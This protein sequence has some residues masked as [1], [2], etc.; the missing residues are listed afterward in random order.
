MSDRHVR[1]RRWLTAVAAAAVCTGMTVLAAAPLAQAASP[2]PAAVTAAAPRVGHTEVR[3]AITPVVADHLSDAVRRANDEGMAALV[4]ELDTPGGLITAMRQIVQT[5]LSAD[6]P[7][8]VYVSP[9]GADAG[10]AGTFVTLAAHVAAMAPATTIGAATPVDVQGGEVGDKIVN[11]AAA[12]A[13]AIATERGRN[14]DFAVA[15]VR[16]GRSI[17]ADEAVKIG[18]VDLIAPNL[19][20]LLADLD[21]RTVTLADGTRTLQTADAQVVEIDW[22]W[23]R[24]LLQWL[25]DPEVA[26]LLISIGTLGLIYELAQPGLGAGAV[27][28]GV[29][30]VL[31]LY[32]LSA[33]PINGAG[34]ALVLLGVGL[35]IAELFIPGI[36]VGAVGGTVAVIIGGLL[37]FP[38]A[39]GV[40]VDLTVL[41][42]ATITVGVL[43][44]AMAVMAARSRHRPTRTNADA[45]IGR[46]ATIHGGP[47]GPR[48]RIDGTYWRVQPAREVTS[49]LEEGRAVEVVDR[50]NLDLIVRPVEEGRSEADREPPEPT[51]TSDRSGP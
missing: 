37:L 3:G 15:A 22:T 21:G 24:R 7:V 48:V 36:G 14:V 16:Q 27:V 17:T 29:S 51:V 38:R 44:G 32:G 23:T 30:L 31:G 6:V 8:V 40:G 43:A 13:K 42:P 20:Q 12:Y 1:M 25:A 47:F 5:F 28:G 49:D 41:L 4:I 34:V 50:D 10:S 45:L 11:N 18:A 19:D 35:F 2:P 46:T 33:L 9:R 26:L 39:S